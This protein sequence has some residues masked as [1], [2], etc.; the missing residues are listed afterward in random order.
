LR[1]VL[2][3]F[4]RRSRPFSLLYPHRRHLSLRVRTFVEYLVAELAH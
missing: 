1:E 4:G 2:P 3:D